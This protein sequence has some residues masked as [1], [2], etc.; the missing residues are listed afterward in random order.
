V[1]LG[2]L[3]WGIHSAQVRVAEL[4]Q[5]RSSLQGTL[6][7]SHRTV[8]GLV[9][10][11]KR[12]L[13]A[14][15]VAPAVERALPAEE[16]VHDLVHQLHQYSRDAGVRIT[17][18]R[19]RA[20]PPARRGASTP[21]V[22]RAAYTFTLEAGAF[23]FLAF[24]E[25]V[26]NHGRFLAVPNLKLT[27]ARRHGGEHAS[28]A[29]HRIQLDVETYRHGAA[30]GS[31]AATIPDAERKL[32]RLEEDLVARRLELALA[33]VPYDGPRGRRDP[34]V[35]PR[36]PVVKP[37]V[38]E[39]I[40][41]ERESDFASELERRTR[42]LRLAWERVPTPGT[43]AQL[44]E[45][46][47]GRRL[48]LRAELDDIEDEYRRAQLDRSLTD[49]ATARRLEGSVLAV[50]KDL[51]REMVRA[52]E[53]D[54]GVEREDLLAILEWM[55]AR[56]A[57]ADW[58]AVINAGRGAEPLLREA[59]A[60]GQHAGLVEAVLR[61][62]GGARTARDLAA[63]ELELSGIVCLRGGNSV[64]LVNGQAVTIGDRLGQ[65][66]TV[67]DIRPGAVDFEFRGVKLSRDL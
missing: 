66:V 59:R 47:A 27:A 58:D 23:Q 37:E 62:C 36:T 35:D 55:R 57:Q 33:P 65:G 67:C 24:L 8:E 16:D 64:A 20:D 2:L 29:W 15:A 4:A 17:G 49:E 41:T 7:T 26:E 3:A 32:A 21:A 56:Q 45:A 13:I 10:L 31:M 11:E 52:A 38:V 39:I 44:D 61:L 40:E 22:E 46:E 63:L 6:V 50:L 43:E 28:P 53:P 18:Y 48:A 30:A 42:R 14:R 5:E 19:R 9:E 51:S 1:V 34:W 54:L 60:R 12:V 25:R